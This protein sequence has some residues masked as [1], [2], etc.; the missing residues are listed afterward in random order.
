MS[1]Q[2]FWVML[3]C[4][5]IITY[6]LRFSFIALAGRF[7]LPVM[8][9]RALQYAPAAVLFALILPAIFVVERSL[10][11]HIDNERIWAGLVA[12]VV[13]WWSKNIL[14]TIV[15]GMLTLWLLQLFT[16]G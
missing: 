2:A 13:A 1:Q 11:F 8:V 5:G 6:L 4:M 7:D 16:F 9:R 14:A 3:V 12:A 10:A 15:V